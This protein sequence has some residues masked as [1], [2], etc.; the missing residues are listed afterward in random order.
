MM[1]RQTRLQWLTDEPIHRE[2][3]GFEV[4]KVVARRSLFSGAPM[5]LA[6]V[7]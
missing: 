7:D 1:I 5:T 4:C 2:D 3:L 6:P